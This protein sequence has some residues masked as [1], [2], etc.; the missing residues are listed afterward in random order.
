MSARREP[1]PT[2]GPVIALDE[3]YIETA[4]A[5]RLRAVLDEA[6]LNHSWHAVGALS[7]AG[8]S[9]EV[10]E[11]RT[12]YPIVRHPDGRTHAPMIVGSPTGE[13]SN[14][15]KGFTRS[16]VE[17]FGTVPR[18]TQDAQRSWLINQMIECRTDLIITDDAHGA[19]ADDLLLL[20]KVT[21]DI[22][23][24]DGQRVGLVL[25]C[26]ATASA[27]PLREIISRPTLQWVQ[28]RRRMSP[29]SPWRYIASLSEAE[30][31]S[32]LAGYERSVLGP[33]FPEVRLGRWASRI[34]RHL[35]HPFFDL[36]GSERVTMQNLRNVVDGILRRLVARDLP[37][38]PD[39]T[40]IDE[41]V[42]ELLAA[43]AT[44][45]VEDDPG[46]VIDDTPAKAAEAAG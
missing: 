30:V 29:T 22:I 11:Y 37:D 16:L 45:V 20:K 24:K 21:D 7:G 2:G 13:R 32:A 8:K 42:A 3:H 40:L 14:S 36:E 35:V 26:A 41:V 5:R 6:R 44:Q 33:L 39:A 34:H 12:L 46:V 19:D 25:L 9:T 1:K 18:G 4:F 27:M 28:F 17:N 31:R 38:I 43:P 15:V 10:D 23:R